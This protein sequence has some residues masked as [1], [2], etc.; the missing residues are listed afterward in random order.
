MA[1]CCS[2]V[3]RVAV[4]AGAA[5]VAAGGT[6]G[7]DGASARGG[8]AAV[9]GVGGGGAGVAAGADVAADGAAGLGAIAL[10]A[11]RQ[12]GESAA[13]LRCRHCSASAPPGVTPEHFDM[14]SERQEARIALCCSGVG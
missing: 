10:T 9:G 8:V 6:A 2:A 1:P 4:A 14:K 7:A 5:G 12:A 11:V 13:E 3:G